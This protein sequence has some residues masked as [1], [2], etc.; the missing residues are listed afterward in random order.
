MTSRRIGIGQAP[1]ATEPGSMLAGFPGY[2]LPSIARRFF[3]PSSYF[4]VFMTSV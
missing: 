1:I 2:L 3:L 4:F